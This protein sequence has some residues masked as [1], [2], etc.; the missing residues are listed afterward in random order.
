MS[1]LKEHVWQK[2]H[3]CVNVCMFVVQ[4]LYTQF[5]IDN[6]LSRESGSRE[7]IDTGIIENYCS[8]NYC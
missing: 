3:L 6:T 5:S 1:S 8:K 4:T 2:L 7:N